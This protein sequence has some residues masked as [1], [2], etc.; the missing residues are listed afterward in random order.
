V[1]AR[2]CNEFTLAFLDVSQPL[3][4]EFPASLR[5]LYGHAALLELVGNGEQIYVIKRSTLTTL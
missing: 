1:L 4:E 3:S 2:S 5:L